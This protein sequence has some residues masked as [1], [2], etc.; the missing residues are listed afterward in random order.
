MTSTRLS[1]QRSFWRFE[2]NLTKIGYPPDLGVFSRPFYS[3]ILYIAMCAF[4][5]NGFVHV[6]CS[7]ERVHSGF[8]FTVMCFVR[9]MALLL[10]IKLVGLTWLIY[11]QGCACCEGIRG[12]DGDDGVSTTLVF[13]PGGIEHNNVYVTEESLAN[14]NC[15]LNGTAYTI[16]FD[17]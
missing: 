9:R 3:L 17:F 6:T 5:S 11:A 14:A 15:R 8:R 7:C 16:Q 12:A 13:R 4:S 1:R 2:W 10:L